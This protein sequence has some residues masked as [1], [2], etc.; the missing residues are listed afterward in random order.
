MNEYLQVI[1]N[2][3]QNGDKEAEDWL[4]GKGKIIIT[5]DFKSYYQNF[6][7]NRNSEDAVN[8]RNKIFERDNYKCQICGSGGKIQAH[9]IKQWSDDIDNR[10]VANNGITLC[11]DCHAKQH[12]EHSNFIKKA[13]Y[14]VRNR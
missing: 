7:G 8:W 5:K 13:K 4:N 2:A 10:F 1:K 11:I 9:H 3:A 6:E 14:H 12:P